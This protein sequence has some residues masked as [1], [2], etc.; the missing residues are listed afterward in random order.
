MYN[1][2]TNEK[3]FALNP[4]KYSAWKLEQMI[5]FGLGGEKLNKNELKKYW[6]QIEIDPQRRSFLALLLNDKH[7]HS[8]TSPNSSS[9]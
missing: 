2:S 3:K 9:R 8:H 5:N 4:D 6:Y 7:F 1:W